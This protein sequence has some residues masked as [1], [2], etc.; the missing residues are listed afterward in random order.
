MCP[1]LPKTVVAKPTVSLDDIDAVNII[2]QDLETYRDT[3]VTKFILGE[4]GFDKWDEYCNTLK[5]IGI[6][7]LEAIYQRALDAL[8]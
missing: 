5:T 3:A 8:K 6:E 1:I 7:D 2:S 4:W